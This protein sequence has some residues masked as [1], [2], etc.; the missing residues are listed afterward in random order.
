MSQRPGTARLPVKC[1]RSV[2][3]AGVKPPK[4]AVAVENAIEKPEARKDCGTISVR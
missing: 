1:T 4:R 2:E 3:M